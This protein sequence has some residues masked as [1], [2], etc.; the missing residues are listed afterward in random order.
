M[1]CAAQVANCVQVVASYRVALLQGGMHAQ[2]VWS[3]ACGAPRA[4]TQFATWAAVD[5]LARRAVARECEVGEALI[6]S[7]G[8]GSE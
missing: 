6:Q 8:N 1:V 2:S 7:V 3:E 4:D 5:W